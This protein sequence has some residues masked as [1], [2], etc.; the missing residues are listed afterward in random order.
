MAQP[1]TGSALTSQLE[2]EVKYAG[3]LKLY[4]KKWCTI[5]KDPFVLSAIQGFQVPFIKS[6]YQSQEPTY[7][8]L[9]TKECSSISAAISPLLC[10]GAIIKC[11]E[12][13]GQFISKVFT[14]RKADGSDRLV[15]NLKPLN[16]FIECQHFKMEDYRTVCNL[17]AKGCFM[18]CIDL[19]DAYHLI[20]LAI[21]HQKYFKFRWAGTLY[22]YTCIPFGLNVAPRLYTKILKPV[23]GY[24][25]KKGHLSAYFLD[26]TLL[27]G[28]TLSEC[29][30]NVGATVTLF[31]SLGLRLNYKKSV[32]NPSQ[33]V[34]FLG[35]V[36][37][38]TLM[39]ITL[40]N[41]KKD[42]IVSLIQDMITVKLFTIESL[43][44]VVGTLVAA[45]PAVSYGQVYVR[46]L[47][48]TK[49]NALRRAGGDFQALT[50]LDH[51]SRLDL[52]WWLSKIRLASKLI[53]IDQFDVIIFTDAS[54]TGWGGS[55]GVEHAKGFW[56]L[57]ERKRHINELELLAVW[58]SLRSLVH[59]FGISI[60]LRVDNTTAISYINRYG[61]CR[62]S[63]CQAIAKAIWTWCEKRLITLHAS[64]INTMDNF[65]A[66]SLS[67][68]NHM[69]LDFKLGPLAFQKIVRHFGKVSID[70]FATYRSKQCEAYI[71]WFPDVNCL[72]VDAFTVPWQDNFYA[73]PPFSLIARVLR[74]IVHDQIQG[75]VIA[76]QWPMQPWYPLFMKLCISNVLVFPKTSDSII[77]P[78]FD[79]PHQ[80]SSHVPLM[81]A[82]LCSKRLQD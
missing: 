6:P 5:T 32:L 22:Q 4:Y 31:K 9:S 1:E 18:S 34:K 72:A 48:I 19:K 39:S 76:P 44:R 46:A 28:R 60:L 64:Y 53:N 62:S 51:E 66:D 23:L 35:F 11:C 54:L 33:K 20:P 59:S 26:D 68:D 16:K 15:I 3:Q 50:V 82:I 49:T 12:E 63:K 17:M 55:C 8:T 45:V 69:D 61:G 7:S 65:V 24:L 36:F 38:S 57:D 10:S 67:R 70:L 27:I 74:K 79:R 25:R 2:S 71:S 75:V 41:S 81:A 56:T 21:Y 43:A 80:L 47:E 14:V 37:D 78:Y 29:N 73:F 42:R 58:N 77:C 30:E 40:P 52:H 13:P